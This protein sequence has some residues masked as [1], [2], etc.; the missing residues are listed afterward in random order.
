MRL[1]VQHQRFGYGKLKGEKALVLVLDGWNDF[2]FRTQYDLYMIDGA[3]IDS[4]GVVKIL[5]RGQK[6]GEIALPVGRVEGDRLADDLVSVGNSVDYYLA[7]MRLGLLEDVS[8]RLNDLVANPSLRP[9]FADEEGYGTSLHRYRPDP[10]D[11]YHEVERTIASG[12]P[13]PDDTGFSFAFR[14]GHRSEPLTFAF[15]QPEQGP[16]GRRVGPSRRSVVVVGPNGVGK[17]DLLARIARVAYAPPAERKSLADDGVIVDGPAF[18]N[19]VAVSYSA[20]DHFL[21]PDLAGDDAEALAEQLRQGT[22]RYNYCG[23]RDLAKVLTSRPGGRPK[24]LG[25]RE[26]EKGFADRLRQIQQRGRR[27]LLGRAMRPILAEQ[28]FARLLPPAPADDELTEAEYDELRL[29][30]FLGEHPRKTFRKL[31]SGH[32]IIVHQLAGLTATLQRHGLALIDEPET[33]LHPPLLAALMTAIRVLLDDRKAY[34]IVATHSP[35]VAQETLASQVMLLTGG[36]AVIASAPAIETY[37]E[38][39]G[40]LTREIFGFH[41]GAGDYRNVLDRMVR[42]YR[43]LEGV[44]EAMGGQLSS[45]ATAHIVAALARFEEDEG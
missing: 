4:V 41:P 37:G 9:T 17:T 13:P 15:G 38:N 45:Q 29:S 32:K 20:F 28:S 11:Y 21:P 36:D 6:A 5:K 2:S 24:L 25:D 14:P 8:A 39:V 34:A 31:S 1:Y 7:L 18:P 40:T 3:S 35:V 30:A 33:H 19:I 23:M 44:E 12:G 26:L 16:T 10:A 27:P 43:T 42:R 22:G